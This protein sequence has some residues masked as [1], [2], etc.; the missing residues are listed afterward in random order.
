MRIAIVGGS[1]KMGAWF[2]RF[3]VADGHEVTL[4]GRNLQRLEDLKRDIGASVSGS[5]DAVAGADLVILSVPIDSFEEVAGEYGR[6]VS[7]GQAVIEITSVKVMPVAAMHRHLK[8]DKVLGVH[9]MFGPGAQ[10]M[11][12]HNFILTPTNGIESRFAGKVREYIEARGGKVSAMSPEEHDR[13]MA[14]VLGLPH[15]MALVAADTLLKLG[16]FDRLERLGGTTCRLLMMLADSVLTEDPVLYASIQTNLH[17]MGGLYELFERNLSEWTDLVR[18]NDKPGFINRM[19]A[20][21]RA[22]H[23][24]DAGFGK[25]YD[26]V[27]RTIE[28]KALE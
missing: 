14:V 3:L 18:R 13:T 15:I 9:P 24:T 5:P 7:P 19:E 23:K 20:L 28:G 1:G 12:N 26:H 11:T 6:H 27:Y 8:T 2:G 22:R 10:D 16:D 17:G 21:G 25:A 4:I